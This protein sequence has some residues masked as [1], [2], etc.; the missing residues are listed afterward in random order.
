MVVRLDASGKEVKNFRLQAVTNFG[1]EIL[2]DGGVIVPIMYQNKVVAYDPDGKVLWEAQAIQ[3]TSAFRLPNGN[4]L[5][6]SQQQP[7]GRTYELDKTGKLIPGGET[8]VTPTL[9]RA[10]RR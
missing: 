9:M 6:T 10:A 7:Q 8:M 1:N 4:T 2:P 3:P 5:V